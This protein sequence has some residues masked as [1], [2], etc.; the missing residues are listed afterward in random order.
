MRSKEYLAAIRPQDDVLVL[1]K[2][3]FFADEVRDP[4]EEIEQLPVQQSFAGKHLGMA[5]SLIDSM[6]TPWD[7]TNYRDTYRDRVNDL[8]EAER[9][10]DEVVT[11]ANPRTTTSGT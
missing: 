8:I 7:P 3:M 9:R 2:T 4:V 1:E 10:G 5:V 6:T 11:A